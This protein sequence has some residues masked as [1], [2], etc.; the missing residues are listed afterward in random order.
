[1]EPTRPARIVWLLLAALMI[2]AWA[3]I[4]WIATEVTTTALQ[5]LQYIVDLAQMTP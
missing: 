1:M 4:S 5:T 3:L 2:A